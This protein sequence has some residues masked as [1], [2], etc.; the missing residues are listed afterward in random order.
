MRR[1]QLVY[2]FLFLVVV[3]FCLYNFRPR[4]TVESGIHTE[5]VSLS[6]PTQSL[7]K[8]IILSWTTFFKIPLGDKYFNSCPELRQICTLTTDRKAHTQ[9][10][11]IVF[12][13]FDMNWTDLPSS[14]GPAQRYVF[15]LHESPATGAKLDVQPG[16]FN[17][18]M[19]Y[20]LD[21]D[22]PYPYWYL[23]RNASARQALDVGKLL[24]KQSSVVWFV[25]NCKTASKRELYVEHLQKYIPVDIYGACGKS[26]CSKFS[27]GGY[28]AVAPCEQAMIDTKYKFYL[29]FENSVCQDYITEKFYARW[30]FNSVPIVLSRKVVQ[31]ALPSNSF[32][33]IDDFPEGPE[34]L[35]NYLK[36]LMNDTHEYLKYF[37]WKIIGYSETKRHPQT[38]IQWGF[39]GIC[40]KLWEE[41]KTGRKETKFYKSVEA[42]WGQNVSCDNELVNRLVAKEKPLTS[43]S[44]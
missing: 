27:K 44:P 7:R 41:E 9:A 39:C 20:R 4:K 30:R 26:G 16:F 24:K 22:I 8:K 5:R 6:S 1:R 29:A 14:R 42:W 38:G 35:A 25:S 32:I 43:K 13:P 31:N 28:A 3:T 33:A 17:W 11:A 37:E 2:F 18:S 12:H 19:T 21:S 34:Q 36:F 40:E 23:A 10:E 15:L